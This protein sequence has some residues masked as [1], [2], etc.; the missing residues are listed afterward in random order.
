MARNGVGVVRRSSLRRTSL[1]PQAPPPAHARAAG[2]HY[3]QR[4]AGCSMHPAGR[5]ADVSAGVRG[6]ECPPIC[7]AHS[8]LVPLSKSIYLSCAT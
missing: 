5:R 2:D 6:A 1:P 3:P 7:R 8:G 4:P